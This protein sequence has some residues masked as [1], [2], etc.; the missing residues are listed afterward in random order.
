MAGN[1]KNRIIIKMIAAIS[2]ICL[3]IILTAS[4]SFAEESLIEKENEPIFE[5]IGREMNL[6]NLS[7]SSIVQDKYGFLW[8]GTQGGLNYYNGRNIKTFKNN[9]FENNR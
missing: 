5:K 6:S 1:I 9:P 8:F 7:V 3:T 2:L 4:F